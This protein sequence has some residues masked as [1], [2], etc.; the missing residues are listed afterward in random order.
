MS[1]L[2][3]YICD[4]FDIVKQIADRRGNIKIRDELMSH[5]KDTLYFAILM[6]GKI[7]F[8]IR[9]LFKALEFDF[10]EPNNKAKKIDLKNLDILNKIFKRNKHICGNWVMKEEDLKMLFTECESFFTNFKSA[11]D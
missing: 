9:E 2:N 8:R 11:L 10:S 6:K 3:D 5:Y 1:T 7:F 4:Y